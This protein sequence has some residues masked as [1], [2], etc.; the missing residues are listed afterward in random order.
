MRAA[1]DDRLESGP[2]GLRAALLLAAFLI[3]LPTPT[4]AQAQTGG[5]LAAPFDVER[6]N[7]MW[8]REISPLQIC[9]PPPAPV[10]DVIRGVYYSDAD[11]SVRKPD[12]F[13]KTMTALAPLWTYSG[14]LNAMADDHVAARQADR[15]RAACVL[16]WLDHWAAGG[17]LLGEISTWAHYDKLWGAG[18]GAAM[19]YLKVRDTPGLDDAQRR[20]VEAWLVAIARATIPE[21]EKY[22]AWRDERRLGRSALS[23]WTAS[24]VVLAGIAANDRALFDWAIAVVRSGLAEVTAEGLLPAE[25]ARKGRAFAYHVWAL[26]PLAVVAAA[27]AANGIDLGAEQNGALHRLVAFMLE[28]RAAPERFEALAGIAQQ[29]DSDPARWPTKD[30]AAAL[31]IINRLVPNARIEQLIAPLRPASSKLSGGNFTVLFGVR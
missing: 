10:R 20:R 13:A 29:P 17:A 18:I 19:A 3:A 11:N 16:L 22:A 15:G 21:N 28:M 26:E 1:T 25:L 7:A 5:R 2:P 9:A 30:G 8:S 24:F 27:G 4:Q 23:Y 6:Q 12:E 14:A 31:E